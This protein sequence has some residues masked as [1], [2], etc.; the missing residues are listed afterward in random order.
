MH[1]LLRGS[2]LIHN[3]GNV[4]VFKVI[5]CV[6]NIAN[7]KLF[8]CYFSIIVVYAFRMLVDVSLQLRLS[9]ER[10]FILDL[11][12]Q[13]EFATHLQWE[14]ILFVLLHYQI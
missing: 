12:L 8:D 5:F 3:N 14:H 7:A 2:V 6:Q 4:P 1:L 9:V 13:L 11:L 10:L